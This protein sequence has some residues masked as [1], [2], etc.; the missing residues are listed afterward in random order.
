MSLVLH[1]HP[2]ASFCWKALIGL[3]ELDIPFDKNLVDLSNEE[4]R[5]RF[6]RLWPIGKFPVLEDKARNRVIPES[7][8][9]LE[10]ADGL[11]H[12]ATRLIPTEPD[13]A[14]ECRLR[15]RFYD[16]Y[17]HL[18]M[19]EIVADR[20]RPEGERDPRAVEETRAR[21][22]KAYVYADEQMRDGPW[23]MGTELTIADC[24]AMP[25]LFYAEKTAP[26]ASRHRNL[27]AYLERLMARPAIARVLAEAEP[28]FKMFPG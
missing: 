28:Y 22:E 21:M 7:T 5:A 11:R 19:Q 3:Y 8:I 26:F 18:P 12:G 27:G 16:M 14:L 4:A 10:Y 13:R 23:A 17:I 25:A 2:L 1:Y 6:Y 20:L 15:D 24:A 9:L